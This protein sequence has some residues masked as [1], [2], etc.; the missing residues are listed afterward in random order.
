M[1][2]LSWYQ[3]LIGTRSSEATTENTMLEG[4]GDGNPPPQKS[5][6]PSTPP[7]TRLPPVESRETVICKITRVTG[8]RLVDESDDLYE[9]TTVDREQPLNLPKD[10]H[11]IPKHPQA[12]T[13]LSTSL[14]LRPPTKRPT[15]PLLPPPKKR[16]L[17]VTA[18]AAEIAS[19]KP[20][21]SKDQFYHQ[22]QTAEE[23]LEM[24]NIMWASGSVPSVPGDDAQ[25]T[26]STTANA[27][28]LQDAPLIGVPDQTGF[29]LY[30]DEETETGRQFDDEGYR[31]YT[32]SP[33]SDGKE[34]TEDEQQEQ[35]IKTLTALQ[36]NNIQLFRPSPSVDRLGSSNSE[37]QDEDIEEASQW[38]LRDQEAGAERS[39]ILRE[40][41]LER[42]GLLT[43]SDN[44]I[45]LSL[46]RDDIS[47]HSGEHSDYHDPLSEPN[48]G[49]NYQASN[50]E[51]LLDI[52][53]S[54]CTT[55]RQPAMPKV[56][57]TLKYVYSS[58]IVREFLLIEDSSGPIGTEIILMRWMLLRE[59]QLTSTGHRA[60]TYPSK[61]HLLRQCT[62]PTLREGSN[63][64]ENCQEF[65]QAQ[66]R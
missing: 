31:S 50:A 3:A 32:L 42:R 48:P 17:L 34:L 24:G 18:Q 45:T 52:A 36:R 62:T 64:C 8:W 57:D 39:R 20:E 11:V 15:S 58:T 61:M 22:P 5:P 9:S 43:S 41:A 44:P 19:L 23:E 2:Y 16:R 26:P 21:R 66:R 33:T 47:M 6:S 53:Q 63:G 54:H 7:C 27:D 40:K 60:D 25:I 4:Q 59:Q 46:E 49:D 13:T 65:R 28:D 30:Q 37:D 55:I 10:L 14:A 29:T 38:M 1:T 12:L 35:L 51:D 56:R